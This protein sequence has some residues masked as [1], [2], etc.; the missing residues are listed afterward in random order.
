MLLL[1][2]LVPLPVQSARQFTPAAHV[3][4]LERSLTGAHRH[5]VSRHDVLHL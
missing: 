4:L 3:S 1:L 2:L 5:F